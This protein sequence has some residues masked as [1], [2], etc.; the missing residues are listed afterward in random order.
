[1]KKDLIKIVCCLT[2]CIAAAAVS[3]GCTAS[4][5]DTPP[6]AE[7]SNTQ[8]AADVPAAAETVS[9]DTSYDPEAF[10]VSD[11]YMAPEQTGNT[12]I[13]GCDTFTQIVDTLTDGMGYANVTLGDTDVLLV[14]TGTYE[15]EPGSF[16]G[17]DAEIYC[18]RDQAPA[19][20]GT[21]SAGGTAYPLS[22]KDG[23]LYVG[24]NHFMSTYLVDGGYLIETEEAYVQ[25]DSH[26]NGTYY[27]RTCNSQFEDYD[28]DSAKDRFDDMFTAMGSAEM[29]SFQTV[30]GDKS[31][32]ASLPA[33]DYPGPELFYTTLYGYLLDELSG[34]YP[35]SQVSIPC[36]VI[37]NVDESDRSDVKVYGDFRIFNYD[38]NGQ[39]LECTSG[40]SYPGCIHVKNTDAGYEITS[41]DIAEDGAGFTESAKRIFGENYDAFM[42]VSGDEKAAE[43]TRAQIIANYVAAND[44]DITAYKDYGREPVKL[45]EENIDSFYS[46]LD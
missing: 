31:V 8:A 29:I 38:L 35:E 33:Y 45:P 21:V 37:I 25:Y 23:Q 11:V 10:T 26:G 9:D 13:T 4:G 1:M 2:V 12:D 19:Y 20:L 40:G 6:A 41:F 28:E 5:T 16:A 3:A 24:G 44:L 42:K 14:S 17:I 15:W 7:E 18:Y 30:G 36:P 22:V 34:E 27:Y 32:G 43:K 46:V 39:T